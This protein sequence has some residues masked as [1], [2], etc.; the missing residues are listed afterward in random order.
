MLKDKLVGLIKIQGISRHFEQRGIWYRQVGRCSLTIEGAGSMNSRSGRQEWLPEHW[1]SSF[2][3]KPLPLFRS[4]NWGLWRPP[5][6]VSSS[7]AHSRS[8]DTGIRKSL[9][10]PLKCVLTSVKTGI[11]TWLLP[12]SEL[13][14]DPHEARGWRLG[15]AFPSRLASLLVF[16]TVS[17]R[18]FC[19][20]SSF[21]ITCA[22][23]RCPSKAPAASDS[24]EGAFSAPASHTGRHSGETESRGNQVHKYLPQN[25]V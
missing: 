22:C 4:G 21:Q 9:L 12:W 10:P 25:S 20:R 14:L 3:G 1:R 16:V 19:L 7:G 11:W 24:G 2:P 8:Y 23:I 5:P 15:A 6:E 18:A 17:S 13:P